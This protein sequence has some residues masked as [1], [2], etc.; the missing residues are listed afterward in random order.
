MYQTD[1]ALCRHSPFSSE[2]QSRRLQER[3]CVSNEE[4]SDTRIPEELYDEEVSEWGLFIVRFL[5]YF[6]FL[7]AHINVSSVAYTFRKE[8]H[9]KIIEYDLTVKQ[10]AYQT[11]SRPNV[12]L[13]EKATAYSKNTS[14][15]T[16]PEDVDMHDSASSESEG[17]GDSLVEDEDDVDDSHLQ[18]PGQPSLP[19]AANGKVKTAR[20]RNERVIA[21]EECRAHLRRLFKNESFMCSLIYGRHGPHAPVKNQISLASADMFFLEV[22]P[23]SPTRFRP[24]AKMGETLFEHPQNELLAKVLNTS[25]KLRDINLDLRTASQKREDSGESSRRALMSQL[26]DRLIQLQVDVNSFMDS[27]KNPAPVRQG[28]LPPAGVK[29][30]LEKKEGLFRKHMM[31]RTHLRQ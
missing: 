8:G 25:Y 11:R 1:N 20:G 6:L 14:K 10:K 9:T 16:E 13:A 18:K 29:Q 3:S 17:E 4:G 21:P 23:V 24:P 2:I 28:K 12:L 30:G 27:S 15:N 7:V 5:I 19:R 31:V 22:I 26:L